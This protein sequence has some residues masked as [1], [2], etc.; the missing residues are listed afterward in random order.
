MAS[1]GRFNSGREHVFV[2]QGKEARAYYRMRWR[3]R[4]HFAYSLQCIRRNEASPRPRSFAQISYDRTAPPPL[5]APL[6]PSETGHPSLLSLFTRRRRGMFGL[7]YSR[8]QNAIAAFVENYFRDGFRWIDWDIH[9]FCRGSN[10]RSCSPGTFEY[11]SFIYYEEG[12]ML[13][14]WK[15]IESLKKGMFERIFVS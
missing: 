3:V 14:R 9:R 4:I 6:R 5:L 10:V 1:G 12:G 2:A 15:M 11:F 13:Y 7:R 8:G